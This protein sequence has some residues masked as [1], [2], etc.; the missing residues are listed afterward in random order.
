VAFAA[1][2]CELMADAEKRRHYGERARAAAAVYDADRIA[3]LW[4]RTI[5]AAIG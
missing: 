2:L 5:A 4:E 1:A 3:D